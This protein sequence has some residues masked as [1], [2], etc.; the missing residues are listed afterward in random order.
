MYFS[1]FLRGFVRPALLV[2]ATFIVACSGSRQSDE[3]AG[4]DSEP[5]IEVKKWDIGTIRAIRAR[6]LGDDPEATRYVGYPIQ[7]SIDIQPEEGATKN[8]LTIGLLS[9]SYRETDGIIHRAHDEDNDSYKRHLGRRAMCIL[10][11][12]DI[13]AELDDDLIAGG[14]YTV[15]KEFVVPETC[16]AARGGPGFPRKTHPGLARSFE[17]G[18]FRFWIGDDVTVSDFLQVKDLKTHN[19]AMRAVLLKSRTHVFDRRADFALNCEFYGTSGTTGCFPTLTIARKA[20]SG[21]MMMRDFSI[22]SSRVVMELDTCRGDLDGPIMSVGGS[23]G[24]FGGQKNP[25]IP[26]E[27]GKVPPPVNAIQDLV[28]QEGRPTDQANAQVTIKYDI[29]PSRESAPAADDSFLAS[30][31]KGSECYPGTTYHPLHVRAGLDVRTGHG[32]IDRTSDN[33]FEEVERLAT[34]AGQVQLALSSAIHHAISGTPVDFN[35]E[36]YLPKESTTCGNIMGAKYG[37]EDWRHHRTFMVRVC[38]IAPFNQHPHVN[39]PDCA[40]KRVRLG[41]EVFPKEP[42]PG[43]MGQRPTLSALSYPSDHRRKMMGG[44][45]FS[46]N[47]SYTQLGEVN[48]ID[49]ASSRSTFM[50]KASGEWFNKHKKSP[51]EFSSGKKKRAFSDIVKFE[52]SGTAD[53]ATQAT[54]SAFLTFMGGAHSP[55]SDLANLSGTIFNFAVTKSLPLFDAPFYGLDL[56]ICL[57]LRADLGLDA[58]VDVRH[59]T[60]YFAAESQF[61][62]IIRDQVRRLPEERLTR[63]RVVA[64]RVRYAIIP[65]IDLMGGASVSAGIG[66]F[67]KHIQGISADALVTLGMYTTPW[68]HRSEWEL[69][70]LKGDVNT[71]AMRAIRAESVRSDFS[72]LAGGI[73]LRASA[74]TGFG[75]VARFS[76]QHHRL[77]APKCSSVKDIWQKPFLTWPGKH[78]SHLITRKATQVALISE[79]QP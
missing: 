45:K 32:S 25:P 18:T 9:S 57:Q 75:C 74:I 47:S 53:R 24:V 62:P 13:E 52:M 43:E 42:A 59:S 46:I 34:E 41:R 68:I 2:A 61:D 40:V 15:T 44:Q 27:D 20:P 26:Q 38:G 35:D 55:A 60:N 22:G 70:H 76:E 1:L 4:D 7:V 31:D 71:E 5:L 58:V 29:C 54:A 39:S 72:I 73:S 63:A 64:G 67:G 11:T 8:R 33:H 12:I 66:I 50:L 77:H 36:L 21:D 14:I 19:V 23:L 6:A 10:G 69:G 78:W 17:E 3:P 37:K 56:D 28:A 79:S 49:G 65:R 51:K 48:M 16:L 30:D